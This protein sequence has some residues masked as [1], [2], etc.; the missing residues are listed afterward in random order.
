MFIYPSQIKQSKNKKCTYFIP[1][2]LIID[3]IFS[4]IVK[5]NI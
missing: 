2:V 1:Q 3:I 5:F 4:E